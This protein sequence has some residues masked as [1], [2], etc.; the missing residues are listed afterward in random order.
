M[1]NWIKNFKTAFPKEI[2]TIMVVSISVFAV[3]LSINTGGT[4]WLLLASL[5]P[6]FLVAGAA[7]GL[8]L[9]GKSLAAHLVLFLTAYLSFG[10]AFVNAISSFDFSSMEFASNFPLELIVGFVI[11]VYL[12][13]MIV[14]HLLSGNVGAKYTKTPIVTS[15][16][17]AFSYFFIR[18]GFSVAVL[19]IAPPVVALLFGG[20][21]F[22]IMLLLAGVAEMPFV[23]VDNVIKGNLLSQPI[24]YFIFTA[25]GLYLA[26]GATMGII[27]SLK[28]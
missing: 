22:A 26:Y 9:S 7:I 19:K 5:A 25:F 21:L 17:I 23:L 2:V 4:I 1:L 6:I 10:T 20:N 27:K 8:E 24:S 18:S 11:F 14:S 3:Y 12:L 15:A 16:I 28:K 13:F